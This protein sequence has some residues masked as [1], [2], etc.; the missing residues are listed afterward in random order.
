MG[1]QTCDRPYRLLFDLTRNDSGWRWREAKRTTFARLKGSVTSA[2]VLISPNPT[3]PFHIEADSSDFATGVVLSQVS[4][5]DQKWHPVAFLSKSLSPV[6]QNYEIHDKE[7]L[8]IIRAL[9]EWWHFIKGAE[10]Q[11][12]IWADHKNL[13]REE[14]WSE[15]HDIGVVVGASTMIGSAGEC[16]WLT[17]RPSGFVME[18]EVEAG[19]VKGPSGLPPVQL[20]G[21]HQVLHALEGL[22]FSGPEQDILRDI[23]QGTKQPKEETTAQAAQE[24]RKSSTHSL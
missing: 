22:Q 24:L 6:E 15:E 7:M 3:K 16:I 5:A 14:F 23:W 8:A 11:C 18:C 19:E 4:L 2:P 10:H 17:H 1:S 20:L 12:E 9:Q 13:Y 21:R